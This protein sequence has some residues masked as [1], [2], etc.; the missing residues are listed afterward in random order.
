MRGQGFNR[1]HFKDAPDDAQGYSYDMGNPMYDDEDG[2]TRYCEDGTPRSEGKPCV[3]CG[4][5][6]TELGH[7]P[8]IANIPGA[9]YAC[10]GHGIEEGYIQ[11]GPRVG[12]CRTIYMSKRKTFNPPDNK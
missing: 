5:H 6:A 1:E 11:Y 4:E 9:V 3:R 2:E 12:E 8:C 7:D 10:C